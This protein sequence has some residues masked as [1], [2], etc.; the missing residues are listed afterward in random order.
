[1]YKCHQ[2]D[3]FLFFKHIRNTDLYLYWAVGNIHIV[4]SGKI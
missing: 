1:M 2:D 4:K 3:V